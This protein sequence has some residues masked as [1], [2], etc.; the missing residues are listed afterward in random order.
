MIQDDI[1][2]LWMPPD[3]FDAPHMFGHTQMFGCPHIS[4]YPYTSVCP[5]AP[6]YRFRRAVGVWKGSRKGWRAFSVWH[7]HIQTS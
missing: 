5:H 6:L 3:V 4:E 1:T 7:L 2:E